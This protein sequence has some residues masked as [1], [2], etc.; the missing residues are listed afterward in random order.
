MITAVREHRFAMRA[1]NARSLKED[2]SP[3]RRWESNPHFRRNAILNRARLPIPPRRQQAGL[4]VDS[5]EAV[6]QGEWKS[7]VTLRHLQIAAPLRFAATQDAS[8]GLNI[9]AC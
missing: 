7:E 8:P 9:E 2:E 5:G 3:Y 6:K 1:R 4:L